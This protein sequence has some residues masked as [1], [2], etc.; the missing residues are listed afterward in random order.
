MIKNVRDFSVGV[1]AGIGVVVLFVMLV[2]RVT[3]EV[4]VIS[5]NAGVSA[6]SVRTM[7]I[8]AGYVTAVVVPSVMLFV[9]WWMKLSSLRVACGAGIIVAAILFVANAC[10]LTNVYMQIQYLIVTVATV[11]YCICGGSLH[12]R[13][14]RS[15]RDS[16]VTQK[17]PIK[18]GSE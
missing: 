12:A 1:V 4:T 18:T 16:G 8:V 11:A 6:N 13:C 3:M 10:V 17:V 2:G 14:N 15:N 9:G 7:S 5:L